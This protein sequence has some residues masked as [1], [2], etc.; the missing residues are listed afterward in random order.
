MIANMMGSVIIT[1]RGVER[2][3]QRRA[4]ISQMYGTHNTQVF[5]TSG[6]AP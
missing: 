5:F 3:E 1:L 4:A 2:I 6:R